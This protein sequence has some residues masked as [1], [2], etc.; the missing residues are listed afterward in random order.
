[1]TIHPDTL[2]FFE[3][4][5]MNN[6]SEWFHDNKPR[7]DAIRKDF[8][9][10]T[11]ALIDEIRPLD[12]S[13]G[14][15][16]AKDCIYRIYRDLRFTL[17]KR[18]YKT[19]IACFLPTGGNRKNAVPGYYLQLGMNELG[20]TIDNRHD[21]TTPHNGCVLGGG[22]FMPQP[23]DLEAIRK[24]I[25]YCIDELKVIMTEPNYQHFFGNT[26]WTLKK[27]SR[28]PKGYDASWPDVDLLKYKDYTTMYNMPDEHLTDGTLF[29]RAVEVFRA[30]VPFNKFIQRALYS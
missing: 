16:T 24:E 12:P 9:E 14:N 28:P 29:H 21:D 11:Q 2:T 20:G 25:Y 8:A 6:N 23:K 4:L 26:F 3:E 5:A 1:M 30:T 19:H 10:F 7:W 15:I 17:D 18:P 27:L 22:I 13:L